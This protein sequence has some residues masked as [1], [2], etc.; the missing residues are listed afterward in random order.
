M[1][2]THTHSTTMIPPE[3]VAA[4]VHH[5]STLQPVADAVNTLSA[6][7]CT[8]HMFSAE[9]KRREYTKTLSRHV[10]DITD[11][12]ADYATVNFQNTSTL[13]TLRILTAFLHEPE[14]L[15]VPYYKTVCFNEGT[16]VYNSTLSTINMTKREAEHTFQ[17][18]KDGEVQVHNR[19]DDKDYLQSRAL[20]VKGR[21]KTQSVVRNNTGYVKC[22]KEPYH[23]L[24]PQQVYIQK[25]STPVCLG[26]NQ[27]TYRFKL[28]QS[29]VDRVRT[30]IEQDY[31]HPAIGNYNVPYTAEQLIYL[32]YVLGL[33]KD[34]STQPIPDWCTYFQIEG[35]DSVK[36]WAARLFLTEVVGPAQELKL[37]SDTMK[38]K[39][40]QKWI[41]QVKKRVKTIMTDERL[42]DLPVHLQLEIEN[43]LNH[44]D[45][46]TNVPTL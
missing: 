36:Y 35:R 27:V 43:K 45:R 32:Y 33:W 20:F 40:D 11:R 30:A 39:L 2:H 21:G 18:T 10:R 41:R 24:Y 44:L 34:K 5:C 23:T 42:S 25:D 13:G 6:L 46:L 37:A 31:I 17:I 8:C 14:R 15:Q 19:D 9:V 12:L 16:H 38:R 22:H 7:A 29:A 4:I 26:R 1:T 3:I 28:P